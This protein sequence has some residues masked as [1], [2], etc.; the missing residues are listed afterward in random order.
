MVQQV[1][2]DHPV[3]VHRLRRLRQTEIGAPHGAVDASD[4]PHMDQVP[5]LVPLAATTHERLGACARAIV[6]VAVGVNVD[7][8]GQPI[9][10]SETRFSADRIEL[11]IENV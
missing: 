11:T 6:L 9:Q 5:G 8:D 10:Y 3:A 1:G 4:L 2:D 7:P